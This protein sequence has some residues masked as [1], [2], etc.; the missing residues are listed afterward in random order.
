MAVD[1]VPEVAMQVGH[2]VVGEE[3]Q[4]SWACVLKPGLGTPG[5][6][7]L[8]L[9]LVFSSGASCSLWSRIL[10]MRVSVQDGS[11]PPLSVTLDLSFLPLPALKCSHTQELISPPGPDS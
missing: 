1:W 2:K 5:S 4:G 11:C 10:K 9:R 3:S 7:R 6:A 8:P